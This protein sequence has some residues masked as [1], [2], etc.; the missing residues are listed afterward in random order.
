M[1]PNGVKS[2][3]NALTK[4]FKTRIKLGSLNSIQ[5]SAKPYKQGVPRLFYLL[6]VCFVVENGILTL[7]LVDTGTHADLFNM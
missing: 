6:S 3:Q 7:T 5:K 2:Q 1:K 4:M